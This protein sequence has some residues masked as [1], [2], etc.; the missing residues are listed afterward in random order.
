MDNFVTIS[1]SIFAKTNLP[2]ISDLPKLFLLDKTIYSRLNGLRELTEKDKRE[3]AMSFYIAY[4]E[5]VIGKYT[6]GDEK[7]VSSN[8]RINVRLVPEKEH[9]ILKI[10]V[11]ESVQINKKV[12]IKEI[13]SLDRSI[14]QIASFH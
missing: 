10:V 5:L 2:E 8:D 13:K 12:D 1:K 6:L 3:R 7:S 11:N 14:K 4:N 9:A